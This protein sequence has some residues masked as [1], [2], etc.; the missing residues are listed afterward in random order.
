MEWNTAHRSMQRYDIINFLI[1]K[2]GYTSFLEIGTEYGENISK[3]ECQLKENIDPDK[4]FDPLTYE[5]T[6]DEA[7]KQIKKEGKIYDIIFIDGLH[8]EKQVNRDIQNSLD[9]LTPNGAIVIHDCLPPTKEHA[10]DPRTRKINWNGTVYK[11]IIHLR[12]NRPDLFIRTVDTDWGCGIVKKSKTQ[13][14]LYNKVD[15]EIAKS[16]EYFSQ[17]KHELLNIISVG[18]FLYNFKYIL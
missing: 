6:S 13:Q 16:W 12:Y 18:D 10:S 2:N 14:P 15:I 1:K 7:F 8:L 4:K 9:V 5:M 17:H 11:S 3:I